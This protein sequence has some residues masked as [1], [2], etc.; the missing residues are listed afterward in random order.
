MKAERPWGSRRRRRWVEGCERLPHRAYGE[1]VLPRSHSCSRTKRSGRQARLAQVPS[2]SPVLCQT[3]MRGGLSHR[4]RRTASRAVRARMRHARAPL[5]EARNQARHV[6]VAAVRAHSQV[7][8][9]AV[10][11]RVEH[12]VVPEV[13]HAAKRGTPRARA[14][15]P[16]RVRDVSLSQQNRVR[17]RPAGCTPVCVSGT[18]TW[19]S[20]PARPVCCSAGPH[21]R[22]AG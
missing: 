4:L 21:T 5:E 2:W 1:A 13:V 22:S 20:G 14:G 17:P 10:A 19:R 7:A 9:H 6:K 3:A 11:A 8:R 12:E 18:R 15:L 16:C